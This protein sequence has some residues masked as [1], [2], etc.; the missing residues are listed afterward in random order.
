MIKIGYK[1]CEYDCCVYVKSLDDGSFI[2]LLL[3]VDDMLIT[4][5]S[6]VEV[7]KLKV[8]LSKEFDMKDL[9]AAK[10]ILG[11]EIRRDRDAKKLRL[12][13]AG[14][15]KKVLERFSMENAKPVSTPLANHFHL[16]TSQCPKTVEETEDM[17]KVPYASAVGCLMYAMVCTRP[18]LAHAVSTV[19]KYMASKYM[20]NPGKQ[21][22]NAVKW[23]FR[24]LKG[25]TDYGITFVRQKSDLSVVGYVDADYAGDLD[26]KRSTTGYVFT[27]A[28]GPICW[29][30]MIQ[31]TVA[32]ST[33][34]AEYMAAAEA[35]KEALWLIGLVKELGIQQGGVSLHCDC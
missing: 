1:R 31:S 32:M 20:A 3:Y 17:S 28:G 6:I 22:W 24:Y 19:S 2:F 35:T 13:Q 11:M 25:T 26:D 12:S 27:L 10:K 8:L 29:K 5:K 34:E 30:S 21:H 7:N 16:S 4:A 23:I 9:G 15:V 14:Y 18:D 33:T